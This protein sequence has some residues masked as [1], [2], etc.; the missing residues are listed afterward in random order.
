MSW[1]PHPT[2]IDYVQAE[3]LLRMTFS[4]DHVADYPARYLRGYCPCAHCQG[5]S[6]GPP[7][8]QEV[9]KPNQIRIDNVTQVGN[10]AICIAWGDGHD[11][12]IYSFQNL[13]TMC[14]CPTCMPDGL[15]E[16]KRRLT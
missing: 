14:P 15:P 4:D 12:G 11:S 9:T 10:Y 16:E 5:H 13:R 3:G 1:Y 2:E 8:W 7:K 6:G